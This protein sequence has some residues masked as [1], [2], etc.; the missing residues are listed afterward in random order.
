MLNMFENLN[1]QLIFICPKP[2]YL[3]LFMTRK[4]VSEFI[5]QEKQNKSEI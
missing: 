2:L 1:V 4:F 3:P 5:L